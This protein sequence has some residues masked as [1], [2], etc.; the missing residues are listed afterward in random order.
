MRQQTNRR[1]EGRHEVAQSML[2]QLVC[3]SIWPFSAIW[4]RA[5]APSKLDQ[6]RTN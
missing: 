6:T 2:S 1:V 5:K 3:L 4:F